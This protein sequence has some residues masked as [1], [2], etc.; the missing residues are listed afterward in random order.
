MKKWLI[1]FILIIRLGCIPLLTA[2]E[3]DLLKVG[4]VH[5]IMKQ[6]LSQHVEKNKITSTILQHALKIYIEQFD[7][8]RMY[9]LQ[10]E[11]EPF[12]HLTQQQLEEII[13][14]YEKS[15]LEIFDQ[16]NVKIQ[17]AIRRS[18]R[19][20]T[21]IEA[22]AK[23]TLFHLQNRNEVFFTEN[24]PLTFA[25]TIDELKI[26]LFQNLKKYVEAQ[27]QRYGDLIVSHR[28]E[29]IIQSYELSLRA[30]ENQYLYEDG[31][32][33]PLPA[34]EQENLFALHILKALASSLDSHTSFYP[35]REAYDLRVRLEKEF[36][37]IGLILKEEGSGV[38]VS[39]LL[40]DAPAA[41]S[42]LI[43]PGDILLEIDGKSVM[44]YPFEKVM[45]LLH[46]SK[47]SSVKLTFKRKG[48]DGA[49]ERVFTVDLKRELII[50]NNGRVEVSSENIGNGIIGKITL[51]SFY[52]GDGVSSEEDVRKAIESLNKKG[53][54]K[55]LI[56]D[57]R[58]N[59]GGFL[60]QA[61]K[62]AGLFITNGVIVISKY[63][64]GK[65]RIYRD[66]DSRESYDGPLII[67]TSKATASAAEIVAQALQ[68]YGVA[69][70]VGDEQTYGKGTI[71]TQ[72][73]TDNQSS[74]YFKVTVG[75]YYTV[76]GKT[77][78][79]QGVKADIVVPS[80]WNHAMIG[81]EY[82]D[83]ANSDTIPNLYEDTLKDLPD[84]TKGWYLK[85]Y[86]P[87]LQKKETNWRMMLPTLE[88]NSEYRIKNN[89][90]YQL[91]LKGEQ[92]LE[93][94]NE[95]DEEY[96]T[97]SKKKKDVGVDDLQVQEANNILKDMI[98]LQILQ[99]KSKKS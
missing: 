21:G 88:K 79:K 17:E 34:V 93:A 92:S 47:K 36:Q 55:G 48:A 40:E 29:E 60:S 63:A 94:D 18:R 30:N 76:S 33:N 19:L 32:G 58:E 81:E 73:V 64:N 12:I 10:G 38:A 15:S 82:L 49:P 8:N 28:K 68:D 87:K 35:A 98:L 1:L 80:R 25:Q 90:N 7:P 11:I 42:G 31:A 67:L 59:G 53:P 2:Q 3:Q 86:I 51:H 77:P 66:V 27:F 72:T 4:D 65:E 54:L 97:V 74:S 5:R 37:G 95:E 52:Q 56:L 14:E 16:L 39:R 91:Y 96:G 44:G 23:K 9:L 41:K 26:R 71:Q 20:R 13:N 75:K 24:T 69:L 6:I 57:L 50:L 45:E 70:I 62:V 84:D 83:S 46:Q 85:Y 22:E 99:D 61:V 43:N 89:K 78:Q